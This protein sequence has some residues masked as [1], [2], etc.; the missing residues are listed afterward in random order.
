MR[1]SILALDDVFDTGLAVLMD[2][3]GT[4]NELATAQGFASPP[5]DVTVIGVR[6]RIRTANGFSV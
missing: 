6:R 1:L 4:A 3:L 2:T 5:F